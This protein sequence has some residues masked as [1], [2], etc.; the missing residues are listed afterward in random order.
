MIFHLAG[1]CPENAVVSDF[2]GDV[3]IPTFFAMFFVNSSS[4]KLFSESAIMTWSFAKVE[5]L[6]LLQ[7]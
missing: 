4:R 7:G 1:S 6:P 5:C 3:S 2:S